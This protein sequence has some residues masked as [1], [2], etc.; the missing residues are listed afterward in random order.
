MRIFLWALAVLVLVLAL[1]GVVLRVA[2]T[3][4]GPAVLSAVDRLTGGTNG[5]A[6]LA[7]LSTGDHSAQKLIIWGPEDRAPDSAPLPVII[8]AHGGSWRTGDP[9]DYS[10][11]ARA[12][13]LEGFIVVL[14]GYRLVKDGAPEG[15]YPAMIEDTAR[16]I[17]RVHDEISHYGGDPDQI[18]LAGH[19]AGAYNVVMVA[20]ER[21]WLARGGHGH[22]ALDADALAGVVGLSG[23]YDFYPFDSDSTRAAFGAALDPEATQVFN[24]V[25]GD[26]PPTLLIHGEKDT[27]VRSRNSRELAQLIETAGGKVTLTLYPEMDHTDPLIAL[28]SPWRSRRDVA[29]T[30]ARFAKQVGARIADTADTTR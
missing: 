25:R 24:H 23:P 19:S 2:I 12:L 10:F 20:F 29:R 11:V 26:A 6:K 13:V 16:A 28:A 14:V 8:F 7:T 1:G 17:H 15:T 30:I 22:D 27:T 3:R 5:A 21:R 4:N 9:E 18:V